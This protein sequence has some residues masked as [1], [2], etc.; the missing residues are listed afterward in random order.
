MVNKALVLPE[1][2]EPKRQEQI[3]ATRFHG[4]KKKKRKLSKEEEAVKR[5]RSERKGQKDLSNPSLALCKKKK[6]KKRKR[7]KKKHSH[8][9]VPPLQSVQARVRDIYNGLLCL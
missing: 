3:A 8:Q 1:R 9:R 6:K 4:P 2:K 5:R 7:E